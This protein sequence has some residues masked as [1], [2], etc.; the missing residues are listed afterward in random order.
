MF[1]KNMLG[2]DDALLA[3]EVFSV[4]D[5]E[6][7]EVRKHQYAGCIEAKDHT[8][9][10]DVRDGD[11]IQTKANGLSGAENPTEYT[12]SIVSVA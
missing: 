3:G 5:V 2:G 7:C 12:L 11:R 1:R 10:F 9:F 4:C 6:G 8:S